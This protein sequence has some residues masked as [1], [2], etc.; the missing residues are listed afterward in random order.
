LLFG[1]K[2]RDVLNGKNRGAAGEF[3]T[4]CVENRM[5]GKTRREGLAIIIVSTLSGME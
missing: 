3:G 2:R 1:G 5:F 4:I